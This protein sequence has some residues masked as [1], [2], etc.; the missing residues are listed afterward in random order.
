[1]PCPF[2]AGNAAA[3]DGSMAVL[4][5]QLD[6]KLLVLRLTLAMVLVVPSVRVNVPT[7]VIVLPSKLV[8]DGVDERLIDCIP[9]P[10]VPAQS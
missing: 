9:M 3:M 7:S 4:P 2:K 5:F 1:M 6:W 8:F 10:L